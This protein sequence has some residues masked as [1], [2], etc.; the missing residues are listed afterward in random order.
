[1]GK[2]AAS[3]RVRIKEDG[4]IIG[5]QSVSENAAEAID[6]TPLPELVESGDKDAPPLDYRVVFTERGVVE[7]SPWWGW[8]YYE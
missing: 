1:M 7:V 8:S 6:E 3:Y 5:Y 2:A 4:T